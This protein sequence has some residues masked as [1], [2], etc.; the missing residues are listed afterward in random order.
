MVKL[1][2]IIKNEEI[3]DPNWVPSK[4]LHREREI[5]EIM[6]SIKL[7]I[8]GRRAVNL[9]IFGR[10]GVGKTACVKYVLQEL[11][12]TSDLTTVYVNCWENPKQHSIFLEIAKKIG[13]IFPSKGVRSD[14]IQEIILNSLIER[15]SVLVFDEV[16]KSERLDFLYPIAQ[17]LMKNSCVILITN[18][19]EFILSLDERIS[20]RLMLQNLEFKDYSYEELQDIL[21]ERVRLALVPNSI[22]EKAF[23]RVVL[24]AFKAMDVR[25]GLFLLLNSARIAEYE[26]SNQINEEHVIKAFE[27]MSIRKEPKLSEQENLLYSIIKEKKEIN[28]KEL[29]EIFISRGGS[30]GDRSFRNYLRKLEKYN[31]IE[32][33]GEKKRIVK[34]K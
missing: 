21:R 24:E 18:L 5:R 28:S 34:L 32:I 10:T 2:Q 19:K 12:R 1:K 7:L 13:K 3:L 29:Y 33:L 26:L 4:I 31:L 11:E 16:D 20:S 30:V 8:S 27:K 25:V 22:T 17:N 23:E 6:E 9:F 14:D 15:K